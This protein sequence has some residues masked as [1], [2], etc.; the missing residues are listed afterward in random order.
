MLDIIIC[1]CTLYVHCVYILGF[2]PEQHS[3]VVLVKRSHKK[4]RFCCILYAT[5]KEGL[6]INQE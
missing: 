5:S 1:T 3:R 6:K 4:L 2:S